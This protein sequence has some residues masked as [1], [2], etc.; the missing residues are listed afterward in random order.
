MPP[1]GWTPSKSSKFS[2]R[3]KICGTI[4][5]KR[6]SRQV[7]ERDKVLSVLAIRNKDRGGQHGYCWRTN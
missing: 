7:Y 5:A 1:I 3:N 2:Q 6:F 4:P